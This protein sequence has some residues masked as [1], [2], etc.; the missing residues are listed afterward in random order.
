MFIYSF[1]KFKALE[2]EKEEIMVHQ[3]SNLITRTN[4][5]K[6]LTKFCLHN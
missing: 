6:A 2:T 1:L 3:N 4:Q 5:I